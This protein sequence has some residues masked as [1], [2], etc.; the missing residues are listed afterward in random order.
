VT[1]SAPGLPRTV[2][3]RLR[4]AQYRLVCAG[5]E[6]I[7][8]QWAYSVYSDWP[9]WYK[10]GF[11]WHLSDTNADGSEG[12]RLASFSLLTHAKVYVSEYVAH[13]QQPLPEETVNH[14]DE[15]TYEIICGGRTWWLWHQSFHDFENAYLDLSPDEPWVLLVDPKPRAAIWAYRAVGD[16][17]RSCRKDAHSDRWKQ[18]AAELIK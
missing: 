1:T 14:V 7:C 17:I 2:A 11:N 16:A 6:F 10:R 12:Y 5:E 3:K 15:G 13:Q 18:R 9:R 4:S 8:Q